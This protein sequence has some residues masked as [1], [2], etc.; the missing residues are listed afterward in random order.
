MSGSVFLLLVFSALYS[1]SHAAD[2]GTIIVFT[3]PGEAKLYVNGQLKGQSPAREDH[4]FSMKLK[5]GVYT[6]EA[7]KETGSH[8]DEY[9]GRQTVTASENNI[10]N[11]TIKLKKRPSLFARNKLIENNTRLSQFIKPKMVLIPAGSF[12]MGCVSGKECLDE[13]NPVHLVHVP[14]FWMGKY[15]V[16]FDEWDACVA[17]SGCDHMPQDRL[18][19]RG[20]RPV[21]NVS[22]DDVQ[23]Y[24]EWIN[25]KAGRFYRLPSEAEWEY[26]ARSGSTTMY[27]WGNRL[28]KNNANCYYC[29]SP[30]DG[31]NTL[32][33]GSYR[34]NGFGLHEM[35]GNVE[36]WTQDCVNDSYKGAPLNGSAW[37]TGDCSR[38]I[39]RGGSYIST[40][41]SSRS[42]SRGDG[43]A[44]SGAE[45]RGF[46]LAMGRLKQNNSTKAAAPTRL[47]TDSTANSTEK[48]ILRI[49]TYYVS[50][51]IDIYINNEYMGKTLQNKDKRLVVKLD[52]GNY[53]VTALKDFKPP[54]GTKEYFAEKQVYLSSDTIQTVLLIPELRPNE[55]IRNKII[56]KYRDHVPEPEMVAIPSG[57]FNMG[58]LKPRHCNKKSLPVHKV[59]VSSFE[60]GKYEVTFKEWKVCVAFGACEHY[61]YYAGIGDD[62]HPIIDVSWS[63]A[64]QYIQWLNK[65]TGNNYRL[66]TEAEWEYAAR[67]G[68]TTEYFWGNELEHDKASCERCPGK[69]KR[70]LA[71]VGSFKANAFGLHDMHGNVEE[72]TQDCS[73]KNYD[74]APTDGSAW[75]AGDCSE[76]MRRGG[77]YRSN[78]I[79]SYLR[80]PYKH[81]I[82]SSKTGL[83]L[84]RD[85]D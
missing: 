80:Y 18:G 59:D 39:V 57:S 74:G 50:E 30:T 40:P 58:C 13:E 65:V 70:K 35:A 45:R 17:D 54:N 33:V 60:L 12:R 55:N 63:D 67:A 1:I 3:E 7:V 23:Q 71:P 53:T 11:I 76:R 32:P 56:K 8:L 31:K 15:E 6:I 42:A 83:R 64:Q 38:R 61:P 9:Y 36:E 29:G 66:P 10:S 37:L 24:I 68:T 49:Y 85:I 46:R 27:P 43:A 81:N 72:L 26:A 51:D 62:N 14:R 16:T 75:E 82:R 22:W 19:N 44:H 47:L 5:S 28:G 34:A 73:N 77:S 25:Q 84:A 78:T 21:T 4:L 41:W 48:G 69:W 52:E 20:D 79:N 2:K